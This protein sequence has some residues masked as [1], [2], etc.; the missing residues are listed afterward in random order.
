[1]IQEQRTTLGSAPVSEEQEHMFCLFVFLFDFPLYMFLVVCLSETVCVPKSFHLSPLSMILSLS[2][3]S[4]SPSFCAIFIYV[5]MCWSIRPP[6]S[7]FIALSICV[8]D[9]QF[10]SVIYIS[11]YGTFVL[12]S[13]KL[14]NSP[15]PSIAKSCSIAGNSFETDQHQTI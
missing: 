7:Y 9:C 11:I 12:L 5:S 2:F 15:T 10:V 6:V 13:D 4:V 8:A 14:H 1:M 3:L